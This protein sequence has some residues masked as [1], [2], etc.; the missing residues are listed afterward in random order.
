MTPPPYNNALIVN[1]MAEELGDDFDTDLDADHSSEEPS[2]A[3][4]STAPMQ[5]PT[6]TAAMDSSI[7]LDDARAY[8]D[9]Q[10]RE[11]VTRLREQA[12]AR[13]DSRD[14]HQHGSALPD[15]GDTPNHRRHHRRSPAPDP[16]TP[17]PIR[18]TM[19]AVGRSLRQSQTD[20]QDSERYPNLPR[21]MR[22]ELE[23]ALHHHSHGVRELSRPELILDFW[24]DGGSLNQERLAELPYQ[25]RQDLAGLERVVQNQRYAPNRR[26]AG[27]SFL[28]LN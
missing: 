13:I 21:G 8:T 1:F 17:P 28:R 23:L 7:G 5:P 2:P 20:E 19:R 14:E 6:D 11:E 3:D 26:G 27:T 25:P 16:T 12:A 18:E 10:L 24:N 22:R 4:H 15:E 9:R